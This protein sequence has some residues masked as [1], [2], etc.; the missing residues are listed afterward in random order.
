ME[1]T[2]PCINTFLI[3]LAL[4]GGFMKYAGLLESGLGR[5]GVASYGLLA[6]N[7]GQAHHFLNVTR[8]LAPGYPGGMTKATPRPW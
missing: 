4:N 8:V 2:L 1:T 6:T 3:E 7:L 5:G